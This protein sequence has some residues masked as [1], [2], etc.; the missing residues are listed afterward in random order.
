MNEDLNVSPPNNNI[1]YAAPGVEL[2]IGYFYD[3]RPIYRIYTEGTTPNEVNVGGTIY[4]YNKNDFCQP[5]NSSCYVLY[6]NHWRPVHYTLLA[7]TINQS[8]EYYITNLGNIGVR[9]NHD[10]WKK[11]PVIATMDFL[12]TQ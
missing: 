7:G 6:S 1:L 4:G 9:I 5:L 2:L 3:N 8:V 12:K 10:S 11:L